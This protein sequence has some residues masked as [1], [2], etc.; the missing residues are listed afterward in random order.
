MV[1]LSKTTSKD[2]EVRANENDTNII[3]FMRRLLPVATLTAVSLCAGVSH[4][5]R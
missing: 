1:S 5:A 4:A 3:E 2:K